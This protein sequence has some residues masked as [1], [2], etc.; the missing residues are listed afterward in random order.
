MPRHLRTACSIGML[1]LL[2]LVLALSA[3]VHA[4]DYTYIEETTGWEATYGGPPTMVWH[5]QV[6]YVSADSGSPAAPYT[7]WE[8]AA[9]TIQDAVDAATTP[10][11]VVLVTNGVYATGGRAVSGMVTNRVT[12]DRAVVVQSVNGPEVTII[13]GPSQ[14]E[15][16]EI[17]GVYLANGAV[18][19]GFTVKNGYVRDDGGG[20][21]CQSTDSVVTNCTLT[22]NDS[23]GVGGGVSGGTLINCTISKNFSMGGG[24]AVDCN[25]VNC[26]LADNFA[27]DGGGGAYDSTLTNCT[28]IS[29]GGEW[30]GGAEY[31]LLNNCT[32]TN[33]WTLSKYGGGAAR[34][35]LNNCVLAGNRTEHSGGGAYQCTLNNCTLTGNWTT[36][37]LDDYGLGGGGAFD[38]VLNN[39]T[40][41]G[42]SSAGETGG[43]AV[44]CTLTNCIIYYN[45]A[46]ATDSPNYRDCTIEYSCTT[47][48]P[49]G[50]GN[51]SSDPM[52]VNFLAGDYH[53]SPS[54][55][56][57]NTGTNHD[58]MLL[59]TDLDRNPRIIF[60]VVDMGAFEWL[61]YT[62]TTNNGTITITGYFGP[63]GDVVIPETI[64]GL[65]V[66]DI[67]DRSF[68]GDNSLTSVTIPNGVPYI[69][70]MVFA[71]CKNLASITIPDSVIG[72]DSESFAGCISL[73]SITIPDSVTFI[74]ETAFYSCTSLTSVTLPNSV[75]YIYEKAFERCT[76]LA[77][78]TIP[79][80]VNSI[81]TRAFNY[82]TSLTNVTIPDSVNYLGHAAFGHCTNLT[83]ITIPDS[84]TR[85]RVGVFESCTSLASVT[86][87]NSV[88]EIWDWAFRG[89]TSLT[90]VT[91][92]DSVTTIGANAFDFCIS[93]TSITIGANVTS[94]ADH[95]FIECSS[96]TGVYFKGNAPT[97][98][99]A[100]VFVGSDL[101]TVYYLAGTMGWEATYGG[102][103]TALWGPPTITEQPVDQTLTEGGAAEFTVIADGSRPLSYQWWFGNA[104]I[105]G[106]I[107]PSLFVANA[108][109]SVAGSYFVVVTNAYGSITSSNAALTVLPAP[110]K[111]RVIAAS[112]VSGGNVVVPIHMTVTANENAL[113]FSLIYDPAVLSYD[114][115]ALGS[116]SVGGS[117][118]PNTSQ[119]NLGKLGI[120]VT[121]P[122]GVSYAP[123]VQE[124]VQVTFL[125]RPVTSPTMTLVDFGDQP[126]PRELVNVQ[127]I[128]LPATYSGAMMQITPGTYEAD[129]APRPN[130]DQ[131][132]SIADWVQ[133]GR[134]VAGL[135]KVTS[136][137]EFQ[138]IDC[139]PRSNRG[140]GN[141]TVTD[142]VQAGRYA[143]GLD[144]ITIVGGPT[145]GHSLLAPSP[146]PSG[147]SSDVPL[148]VVR[149]LSTNSWGGQTVTASL[150]MDALGD[151]TAFGASLSFDSMALRY[152]SARLGSHAANSILNVNSNDAADGRL[153]LLLSLP[154]GST[155]VSGTRELVLIDFQIVPTTAGATS[156]TLNDAPVVREVSD[157]SANTLSTAY[158]NGAVGVLGLP[159]LNAALLNQDITLSWAVPVA[160]FV[161]QASGAFGEWSDVVEPPTTN[162]LTVSITVPLLST[163]QFFRLRKN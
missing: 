12:V 69:R 40:L 3:A 149:V 90:S 158:E 44:A 15:D 128:V 82:C 83:S 79:N 9:H 98:G 35:T 11:A 129:V 139:A 150:E 144:P 87:P 131:N 6:H 4:Q 147:D 2:P 23:Y 137:D 118:L 95:A 45:S 66:T 148:R 145:A 160:P 122:I 99:G 111:I 125:A 121:L 72:I 136:P 31:C 5:P 17:R 67:W 154:I 43:G 1:L 103:P 65:P 37:S 153:G 76:S 33:N 39:C 75:K 22:D 132:V 24:G 56:C 112:G 161:L 89:C 120:A 104:P 97:L 64:N 93:L 102:R 117:L 41:T 20:V 59:A 108:T 18:L 119:T 163:N 126:T 8:T 105:A 151:E 138:R 25:L 54:S 141:L 34:S 49:P 61:P 140:N 84:V 100:D 80:S 124:V 7:S 155:L 142:W 16:G 38:C 57:V 55:P 74:G 10:G 77:S 32:L 68:S 143:A 101:V 63:G 106:A 58:W 113:G 146:Q 94:I 135:D 51:I 62:Y 85:I 19:S 36:L 21:W 60:D 73:A 13:Q 14:R 70:F 123:G 46:A 52:F 115:I 130:G 162:G 133:V 91:I 152:L 50:L 114:S 92:P 30:A 48:L 47:P 127:A 26:T 81:G 42:N 27:Y 71:G 53:L 156:L 116:G 157:P 96:L 134:F 86:I 109:M 107:G 159:V 88:T 110:P 28:L 78:V 29:N